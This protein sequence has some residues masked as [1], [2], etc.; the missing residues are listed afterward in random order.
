MSEKTAYFVR[1]SLSVVLLRLAGLILLGQLG[2]DVAEGVAH[3]GADLHRIELDPEREPGWLGRLGGDGVPAAAPAQDAE[4][5]YQGRQ[6]R[7]KVP[8]RDLLVARSTGHPS[9]GSQ[10]SSR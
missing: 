5:N 7:Q 10:E 4:Q 3:V 6:P 2:L 9:N 1:G 8:H